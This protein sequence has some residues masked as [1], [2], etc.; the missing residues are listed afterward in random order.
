MLLHAVLALILVLQ[1]NDLP[2]IAGSASGAPGLQGGGGGGGGSAGQR[3]SDVTYYIDVAP[4]PSEAPETEAPRIP[5]I[6]PVAVDVLDPPLIE[7]PPPVDLAAMLGGGGIGEGEG[8]GTGSGT[9]PGSGSGAG[10]G[11]GS[12]TGPGSGSGEGP[13]SGSG[14]T[15]RPPEVIGLIWPPQ[16]PG[17]VRDREV[18]VRVLVDAN[19][20]VTDVRLLA[21]SGNGRYDRQLREQ[22]MEWRFRPARDQSGRA[23]AYPYEYTFS[24]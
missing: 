3:L 17:N 19:G 23:I 5:E 18:T 22:A 1:S 21:S 15:V 12:G 13:G 14:G 24:F 4:L 7:A 20:R 6:Q 2:D 8:P 10:G 11:D 16:P 9:G